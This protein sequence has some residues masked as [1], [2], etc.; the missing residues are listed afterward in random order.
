MP[1][2]RTALPPAMRQQVIA[3]Q[4]DKCM[5]CFR[6][7]RGL[8]VI[9]HKIPHNIVKTHELD[10]LQALCPI[11]HDYKTRREAGSMDPKILP[12]VMHCRVCSVETN[13]AS[14]RCWGCYWRTWRCW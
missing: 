10:N 2:K 8:A 3:R 7:M 4:H 9:D 13:T 11:C 14:T 12:P 1:T 6:D 5:F